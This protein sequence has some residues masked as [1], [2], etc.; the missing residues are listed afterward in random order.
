MIRNDRNTVKPENQAGPLSH[1]G[2]A[3]SQHLSVCEGSLVCQRG[4]GL[5]KQIDGGACALHQ[6]AHNRQQG[7]AQHGR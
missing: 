6:P 3:P 7:L 5:H 2:T 4:D 1:T